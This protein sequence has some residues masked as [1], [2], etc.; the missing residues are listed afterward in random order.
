[1][2]DQYENSTWEVGIN[3]FVAYLD[4]LGFKEYVS[5]ESPDKVYNMMSKLSDNIE[6]IEK[7]ESLN[8][9]KYKGKKPYITTFSDS[10]FIFSFDDTLISF[11]IIL[12][13]ISLLMYG[14]MNECVLPMKGAIAHGTVHVDKD[15]HIYCGRPLTDAYLLQE[16]VHYCGIVFHNSVD[17]YLE[18]QQAKINNELKELFFETLTPFK[19]G[20][21]K[22]NNVNWFLHI[23]EDDFNLINKKMRI[24]TSGNPRRYSDNTKKVFDETKN[25]NNK[26]QINKIA[27][28]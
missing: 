8:L 13:Y 3:R 22:H 20:C 2:N 12:N 4:F 7:S 16:D 11:E 19:N 26:K 28:V 24:T 5:R 1:M 6:K 21:I 17:I 9:G 14:I 15:K 18:K 25:R 27:S 10:V 23:D